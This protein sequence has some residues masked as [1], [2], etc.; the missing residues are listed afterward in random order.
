M[1]SEQRKKLSVKRI[2]KITLSSLITFSWFILSYSILLVL[3]IRSTIAGAYLEIEYEGLQNLREGA[4]LNFG[5]DSFSLLVLGVERDDLETPGYADAI[6]VMTVNP[7]KE[8]TNI[9]S[10]SRDLRVDFTGHGICYHHLGFRYTMGGASSVVDLLQRTFNLPIDFVIVIDMTGFAVLIDE[11]D[12]ITVNNDFEF[13]HGGYHFPIGLIDLHGSKALS[14]VRMRLDDLDSD[15]GRQQRQRNVAA[16]TLRSLATP[17]IALFRHNDIITI[18]GDNVQTNLTP[19]DLITIFR[20]Y[21]NALVGDIELLEF[22]GSRVL[23][24]DV[25]FHLL[26][27]EQ[28]LEI[29]ETLKEHLGLEN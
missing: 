12:G 4:P 17:E 19:A 21:R 15:F 22:R 28:I 13:S 2:L 16:E 11:V 25:Y 6:M 8:S 7:E 14:F 3:S 26:S 9:L 1:K 5:E 29:S 23:I 27:D 20:N 10:L 18:L 24:N